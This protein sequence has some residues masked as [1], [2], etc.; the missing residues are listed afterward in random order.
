MHGGLLDV[1]GNAGDIRGLVLEVGVQTD[2]VDDGA[3]YC[4]DAGLIVGQ[5]YLVKCLH[6]VHRLL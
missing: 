3:V 6:R 4:L 5:R 2:L 1:F